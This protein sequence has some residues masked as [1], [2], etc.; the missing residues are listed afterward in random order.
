MAKGR[1][2]QKVLTGLLPFIL[3]AIQRDVGCRAVGPAPSY[4]VRDAGFLGSD[5][6]FHAKH[7]TGTPEGRW[8]L[9]SDP[10]K[11]DHAHLALNPQL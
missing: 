10:N 6:N 5:S 9:E 1:F 8:N 4:F 11:P 2:D 3:G 7:P